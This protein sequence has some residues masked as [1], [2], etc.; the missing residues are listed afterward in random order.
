MPLRDFDACIRS[1]MLYGGETWALTKRL[2]GVLIGCDR[3]MLRYMAGVTRQDRVSSEEVARRC[4][5]GML[6]DALLRRLGWFG[7]MER[8]DERD[9]LGR[10]RLVE[11]PGHR[12]PGRL[13]KTW[14]KNMEEELN[15]FQLCVVQV[16][17][18]SG[19]RTIIDCLTL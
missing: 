8:R 2:E 4:G 6:G 11:A 5:V 10:V 7:H 15:R 14:K 17:D 12:L 3:R 16:Q 9:D 18:K 19:W 1:V 13:K